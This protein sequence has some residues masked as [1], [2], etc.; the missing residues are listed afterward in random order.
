MPS[1]ALLNVTIVTTTQSF[2]VFVENQAEEDARFAI[3][4]D[5]EHVHSR[6]VRPSVSSTVEGVNPDEDTLRPFIFAELRLTG[7]PGSNFL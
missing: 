2:E 3:F 7:T 5:G 4:V 1:P 6:I